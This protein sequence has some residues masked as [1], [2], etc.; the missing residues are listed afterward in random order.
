VVRDN[1]KTYNRLNEL[2][3]LVSINQ[4]RFGLAGPEGKK[5]V[6]T[7]KVGG[8]IEIWEYW[9]PLIN[10]TGH[11]ATVRDGERY[12]VSN[13]YRMLEELLQPPGTRRGDERL[14][15]RSDFNQL[16]T[17]GLKQSNLF[18]WVNPR[19]LATTLRD[20]AQ[21]DAVE[22]VKSRIDWERERALEEDKAIKEILPGKVRGRL[23][24]EEQE[25]VNSLVTPRLDSIEQRVL[26]EQVPQMR[27]AMERR[28]VY[29]EACSGALLMLALDPKQFQLTLGTLIPLDDK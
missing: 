12:I 15:D 29:A 17:E 6:Y 28:I 14:S 26:A 24:P 9:S 2:Q 5:A 10:G 19:T 11:V 23:T 13:S 16:V 27:A 3:N 25:Q 4:G 8:A 18:L 21:L 20:F 1:E 22:Q 7:H